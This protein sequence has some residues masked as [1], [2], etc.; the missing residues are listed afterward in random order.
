MFKEIADVTEG[1][2][3]GYLYQLVENKQK[4]ISQ[5]MTSKTPVRV[6]EDIDEKALSYAEI[7]ALA[8]G[9]PLIIEKTE[10]DTSVS[11]LRL[12]KQTF[13]NQVYEIQDKVVKYY[14]NEIARLEKR[15]TLLSED[16]ERAKQNTKITEENKFSPMT[17]VDTIYTE[18]QEA[19][20]QILELCKTM[21]NP[22]PIHIGDFRGFSIEL[23]FE[24]VAREF[25]INLKG[26]L[27]HIV[28]LGDDASGN[29]IR[30]D[31]VLDNLKKE[32]EN[33]K[34]ILEDTK[35]Q[36]ENAKIEIQKEFPQEQE[37]KNKIAR[38]EQVNKELNLNEKEHE[39]IDN[40]EPD[41]KSQ[42]RDFD[43]ER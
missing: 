26:T 5:I 2:F 33:T 25:R 34:V 32:L 36:F 18:R 7:K 6:A 29:T 16:I 15:I 42:E 19:G 22:S 12:L 30:I 39:I 4:F 40:D 3:D 27:S 1:T 43:K 8:A 31:N 23:Y 9:N 28:S 20:K 24:T 37:L 41:G 14:P 21:K 35:M 13:L 10:L 17:L 11:K 38:L